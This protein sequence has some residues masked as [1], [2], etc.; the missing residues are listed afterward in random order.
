MELINILV[1][2][3][4]IQYAK[5]LMETLKRKDSQNRIGQIIVDNSMLQD[6]SLEQYDAL[7][8]NIKFDIVL[9]DYQLGCSY[10][11]IL[12]SAWMMLHLKVPRMTFTSGAYPG[13]K[14][15]F[16][17]YITKDEIIDS[18][19]QVIDRIALCVEDFNYN[20]W[21]EGQFE[22]LVDQYSILITED[23]SSELNPCEKENLESLI[24]LLDKFEKIIDIKQEEEI[25]L[26]MEHIN[27]QSNF[28]EKEK[29]FYDEVLSK[30]KQLQETL[31][32]L[33]KYH[34]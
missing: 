20:S 32:E 31:E 16:D 33:K 7:I 23:Q 14:D 22:K 1:I 8:H 17:G 12:V 18:P 3:D 29:K 28:V 26:K 21:L 2:D 34:E 6:Q 15:Y 4:E 24:R 9:I 5:R 19:N 25:K 13:P 27:N 11:G 10:T 30:Q